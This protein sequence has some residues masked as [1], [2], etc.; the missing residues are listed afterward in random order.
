MLA[1]KTNIDNF[2]LLHIAEFLPIA[3]SSLTVMKL[4]WRI[5]PMPLLKIRNGVLQGYMLMRVLPELKQIIQDMLCNERFAGDMLLQKTYIEN[6]I[7]KKVKK[8]VERWLSILLPII[9]LPL[10]QKKPL[11]WFKLK[12]RE[13]AANGRHRT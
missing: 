9:I 10:F 7:N 8:I 1:E 3:T 4:S 11:S 2:V 5:T 6:C 12:L 13:E